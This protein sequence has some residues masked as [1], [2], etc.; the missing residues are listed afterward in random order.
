MLSCMHNAPRPP[1]STLCGLPATTRRY[2]KLGSYALCGLPDDL[3]P[4]RYV[5]VRAG[6]LHLQGRQNAQLP[7]ECT[8]R[9]PNAEGAAAGWVAGQGLLT[10]HLHARITAFDPLGSGLDVRFAHPCCAGGQHED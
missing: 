9:S 5:E 8:A 7:A 3:Y 6:G 1:L 10:W 2:E 4:T